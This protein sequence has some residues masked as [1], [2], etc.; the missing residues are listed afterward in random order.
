MLF[1]CG[2]GHWKRRINKRRGRRRNR[3]RLL[4]KLSKPEQ[5][6]LLMLLHC[7]SER[8][9]VIDV[10]WYIKY[11]VPKAPPW[12]PVLELHQSTNSDISQYCGSTYYDISRMQQLSYCSRRLQCWYFVHR[13]MGTEC[14]FEMKASLESQE[15]SHQ[16][17]SK[18]RE[19]VLLF[20]MATRSP[21]TWASVPPQ[22]PSPT[23]QWNNSKITPENTFWLGDFS[24]YI[25]LS[26]RWSPALCMEEEAT[27][28]APAGLF[29]SS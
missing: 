24:F 25:C 18:E 16:K 7:H 27:R 19:R 17:G 29:P 5:H 3:A 12:Q 8:P 1:S 15:N 9:S 13:P 23:H 28:R 22:M 21:A 4:Q 6:Q 11:V 2:R 26:A 10:R 20:R 14:L